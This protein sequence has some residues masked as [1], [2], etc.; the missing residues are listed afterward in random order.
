MIECRSKY[1]R[2]KLETDEDKAVYDCI[3]DGMR[4]IKEE[5]RIDDSLFPS[6]RT[7]LTVILDYVLMDN[8][9]LFYVDTGELYIQTSPWRGV[10]VKYRFP[11]K[12]IARIEAKL[13]AAVYNVIAAAAGSRLTLDQTEQFLHDFLALNVTYEHD[14]H[15]Y[16]KA[17]SILGPIM[18]GR[19][20]CEGYAKAFKL[21]CDAAGISCI[22][23]C[24][25]AGDPVTGEYG[26]HA[27][28]VVK[29]NGRCRHVDVTWD[30]CIRTPDHLPHQYYNLSDAEMAADHKWDRSLMPECQ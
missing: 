11:E 13:L 7:P 28:N 24:G 5:I 2:T 12:E 14:D 19:S 4:N 27:W 26:G 10:I 1:Y 17:H 9:G 23:I 29:I 22:V 30:S 15:T 6:Y 21:L 8:P 18:H 25:D 20:V 16:H 3:L